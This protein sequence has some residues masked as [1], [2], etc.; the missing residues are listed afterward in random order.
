MRSLRPPVTIAKFLPFL[1][2]VAAFAAIALIAHPATTL[3][4]LIGDAIVIIT[5]ADTLGFRGAAT[6]RGA[7]QTK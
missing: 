4:A 6:S 2:A 5:I 3:F 1:P 7:E